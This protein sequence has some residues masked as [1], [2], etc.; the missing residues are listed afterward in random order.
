MSRFLIE[1]FQIM[2]KSY[3]NMSHGFTNTRG[4]IGK[5]ITLILRAKFELFILHEVLY[6]I[7]T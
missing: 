7:Q 2:R 5:K 1:K 3:H 4:V 6:T